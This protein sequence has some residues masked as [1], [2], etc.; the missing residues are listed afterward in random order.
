MV[1]RLFSMDS[2][3]KFVVFRTRLSF[4]SIVTWTPICNKLIG[5]LELEKIKIIE[6]INAGCVTTQH[7]RK[8]K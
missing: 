7:V 6:L 1:R 4:I 2:S 3:A 5:E 8:D